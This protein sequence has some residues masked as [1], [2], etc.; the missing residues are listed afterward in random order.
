MYVWT[1]LCRVLHKAPSVSFITGSSV[2]VCVCVC[3]CVGGG[4]CVCVCVGWCVC[5]C[6]CLCVWLC[7]CVCACLHALLGCYPMWRSC[8]CMRVSVCKCLFEDLSVF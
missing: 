2:C 6:V 7:S 1:Q 4:V 8:G 3:V 5:V